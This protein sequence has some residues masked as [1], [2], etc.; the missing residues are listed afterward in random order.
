MVLYRPGAAEGA[1][2]G[3]EGGEQHMP[4]VPAQL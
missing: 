2:A 1:E 4:M 3:G